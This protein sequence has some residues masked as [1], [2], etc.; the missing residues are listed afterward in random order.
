MGI[1]AERY[2]IA[3]PKSGWTKT[4][5]AGINERKS[6]NIIYFVK[7]FFYLLSEKKRAKQIIYKILPNSEGWK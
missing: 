3:V 2:T 5:A 7:L 1:I 4:S 6:I